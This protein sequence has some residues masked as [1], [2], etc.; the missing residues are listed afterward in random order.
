MFLPEGVN[1]AMLTAFNNDGTINEPV[2]RDWVDFMIQ[3]GINGLFPGASVG[4]FYS[5]SVQDHCCLMEIVVEQAAGRVPVFPGVS[6]PATDISVKLAKHAEKIGCAAVMCLPPYY[7]KV[8]QEMVKKHFEKVAKAVNIP[9]ILYNL[10]QLVTPIDRA[11]FADL[12]GI[13][14]IVAIKDSSGNMV[15]MV[16]MMEIARERGRDDFG[17]LTGWDDI[18]Y[19]ALHVG[20]KGAI[21]GVCGVIPE[22]TVPIYK[23]F[24]AGNYAKALEYQK[25][26]LPLLSTMGMLP[27][28]AGYKLGLDL[29]GFDTGPLRQPVDEVD[30]YHYL[31]VRKKL[32]DLFGKAFGANV[33]GRK[34]EPRMA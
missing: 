14:N 19:P 5:F 30:R 32:Q 1:A 15:E 6:S 9:V 10:P 21:A 7:T 20:A 34:K 16:H 23:E 12:V 26:A 13:R 4:E 17:V 24:K 22:V 2:M 31:A 25:A 28:P 8:S 29:R 18:L 27:F 11:T 33:V 3:K